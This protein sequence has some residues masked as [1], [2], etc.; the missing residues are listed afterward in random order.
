MWAERQEH[1]LKIGPSTKRKGR[2]GKKKSTKEWG[3]IKKG[4]N[5][6]GERESWD[7]ETKNNTGGALGG[8]ETKSKEK[9]RHLKR[10]EIVLSKEVKD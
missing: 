1:K 2:K 5:E 9:A 4:K 10:K 3:M 7:T 8:E 6:R